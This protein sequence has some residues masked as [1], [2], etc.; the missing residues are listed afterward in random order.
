MMESFPGEKVLKRA[1]LRA[2]VGVLGTPFLY[3]GSKFFLDYPNWDHENWLFNGLDFGQANI[4]DKTW[5][6]YT[7][8]KH[9]SKIVLK[10]DVDILKN[11]IDELIISDVMDE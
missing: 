2:S 1:C 11:A 7:E 5:S 8:D 10:L 6:V 3:R 9:R 4:P